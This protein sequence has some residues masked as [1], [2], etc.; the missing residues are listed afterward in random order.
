MNQIFTKIKGIQ[1]SCP[2]QNHFQVFLKNNAN[3]YVLILLSKH[4]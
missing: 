3:L 2:H 4:Y 1:P